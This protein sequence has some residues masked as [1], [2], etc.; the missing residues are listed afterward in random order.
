MENS[1]KMTLYFSFIYSIP[2][3]HNWTQGPPLSQY[4]F[5]QL[6][7]LLLLLLYSR[8]VNRNRKVKTNT[9]FIAPFSGH[10]RDGKIKKRKLTGGKRLQVLSC[11]VQNEKHVRLRRISDNANKFSRSLQVRLNKSEYHHKHPHYSRIVLMAAFMKVSS[12]REAL[13]A[14]K[15][16][17]SRGREEGAVHGGYRPNN[18]PSQPLPRGLAASWPWVDSRRRV[19]RGHRHRPAEQAPPMPPRCYPLAALV[20]PAAGDPRKREDIRHACP[21]RSSQ[22]ATQATRNISPQGSGDANAG[23]SD[24]SFSVSLPLLK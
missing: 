21:S 16:T 3:S 20:P 14:G 13:S 10:Q 7:P 2:H 12:R 18:A 23:A 19:S 15:K 22:R 9:F 1:Q 24:R 4:K 6:L 17:G 11:N 8:L 5:L